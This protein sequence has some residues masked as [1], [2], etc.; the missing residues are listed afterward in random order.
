[1]AHK[2]NVI[3]DVNNPV[4][5]LQI[6]H[7]WFHCLSYNSP[8]FLWLSNNSVSHLHFQTT[9]RAVSLIFKQLHKC[10]WPSTSLFQQF[11]KQ[12]SQLVDQVDFRDMVNQFSI[13]CGEYNVKEDHEIYRSQ[14]SKVEE[15][16]I[17]NL[18]S[19]F[20]TFTLTFTFTVEMVDLFTIFN[21][22]LNIWDFHLRDF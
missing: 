13:R 16:L 3:Q 20:H 1:M 5:S 8:Q 22:N 9:L 17:F 14:E 12:F 7:Q 15:V 2:F 10:L 19:I 4:S 21:F 18:T 11:K 6:T